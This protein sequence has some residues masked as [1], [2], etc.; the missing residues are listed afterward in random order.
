MPKIRL[1]NI[2]LVNWYGFIDNKIPLGDNLTLITGEN[3]CGKSTI[4]DAVKYAFSG[5]TEFNKSTTSKKIGGN[6]RTLVS[7]TRCLM[8]ASAGIFARPAEKMPNVY[9]HISLEYYDEVNSN[10]FILGV[11][12]ETNAGN[13]VNPYWYA[14]DGFLMDDISYTYLENEIMKPYD[15]M[16][17]QKQYGIQIMNRKE[18]LTRFMQM[19]GLK[20]AS[21][22]IGNFQRKLRSI[23]TYDPKAKIQEFIK[24]SVLEKHD[25]NFDKLKDAKSNIEKIN[26]TLEL[27]NLEI[28]ALDGILKDFTEHE[29]VSLRLKINEVKITYKEVKRIRTKID[30]EQARFDQ[31]VI[32]ANHLR[33]LIPDGEEQKRSVEKSYL[34]AQNHLNEMDVSKAIEEEKNRLIEIQALCKKMAIEKDELSN[35]QEQIRKMIF[36]VTSLNI[37]EQKKVFLQELES[38]EWSFSEKEDAVHY[39][40]KA[41]LELRDGCIIKRA[42]L[43][44]QLEKIQ[45]EMIHLNHIIDECNKSK[46]DYSYVKDQVAFV[47]EINRE[48]IKR[49]IDSEARFACEYVIELY[50][51]EWRSA[52]EAFLGIHRYAVIVEPRYFDI[53]NRILDD[54]L[55]KYVELVNTRI[56]LKHDAKIVDNSVFHKLVIKNDIASKYFAYWLGGISA[57][58]IKEVVN[59]ENAMSKE[60]KLSRNMAVTFINTKKLKTFTLGQEAIEINLRFAKKQIEELAHMEKQVLTE[61]KENNDMAQKTELYL[62]YFKQYNY[63]A[64]SNLDDANRKLDETEKKLD[65]LREAQKNNLEYVA[66]DKQVRM[67]EEQ[68]EQIN[69]ELMI[70]KNSLNR[71]EIEN[72]QKQNNITEWGINLKDKEGTLD[73]LEQINPTEAKIAKQEY[74]DFISG[75]TRDGD[76]MSLKNRERRESEQR[77]L[78]SLIIGGQ[79]DYNRHKSDDEQLPEGLQCEGAYLKRKNKIWVDDLQDINAKMG[80]QTR[81]Y[82]SIFKNE[83]VLSIYQTALTA[84]EDIKGINRELRQLKFSTKYQFDVNLLDDKSDF[85]KILRYA[86]FLKRTNKVDDGQMFLTKLVGYEDDEVEIREEEIRELINR[87]IDKNDISAIQSFADYRNYMSYEILINNAEITNGRLSKQAGYDSGAG[88]QI[89]YTLILSA[90]LSMLYNQRVYSTRLI[91]IDEPFEKMSDNNIKRMLSFFK[92]QNFQVI[93]CAPPN[94]T[95]SIGYECD[96]IIPVLK[97]RND[98][99][100]V[101]SV[102]FYDEK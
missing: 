36:M 23:M 6:R 12:L 58:D 29:R 34:K 63:D 45:A 75:I 100:Q 71:L 44:N 83:F 85:G 90:A 1:K 82:E 17:F 16:K 59:H 67:F 50:D 41:I 97:L 79:K 2:Y 4:L 15:Y 68:L 13:N 72:E 80:A 87:I 66:L 27:I 47:S 31:N 42:D 39:L 84:K 52:I 3:E 74:D 21:A 14:M 70:D 60:G 86:E 57:V 19:T 8:D 101:G 25:V 78:E 32:E 10:T 73:Y 61:A 89:P 96:V 95:D 48:F 91:F 18:A 46:P 7:Y 77:R 40:K 98:N 5:D 65:D 53:A 93:F 92:S 102:Q 35:F 54:S 9:S 38:E 56:L 55:Y 76:I 33:K 49:G 99:M 94:R 64:A 30:T 24:E 26:K 28:Q 11:I 51:E 20:F 69:N 81:K 37:D 62:E 22:E 88:T 43:N